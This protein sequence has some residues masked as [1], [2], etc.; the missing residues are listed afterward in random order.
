MAEAFERFAAG[1][2]LQLSAERVGFAP[3]DVLVPLPEVQQHYVVTLSGPG[4]TTTVFRLIFS[5]PLDVST[6]PAVGDVL[7]WAAS[8]AWLV[9]RAAREL[10]PWAAFYGYPADDAGTAVLFAQQVEQTDALA[11]LLGEAQYQRLLDLYDRESSP[12]DTG[13]PQVHR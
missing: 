5:T 8:D 7:W 9:E 2:G 3:R 12:A 6:L 4:S 10:R 11:R 13:L 1:C